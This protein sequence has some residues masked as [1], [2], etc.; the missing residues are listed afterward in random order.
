M[1]IKRGDLKDN[2]AVIE[3]RSN[4]LNSTMVVLSARLCPYREGIKRDKF[5]N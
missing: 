5:P 4:N 2:S 3:S 1:E